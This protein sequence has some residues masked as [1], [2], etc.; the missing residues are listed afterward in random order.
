M[1]RGFV[2]RL[3][4]RHKLVLITTVTST[5][6]L[7]VTVLAF[8]FYDRA[9]IT[10]EMTH[11]MQVQAAI[12][13]GN[14]AAVVA[15]GNSQEGEVIL[16]ALHANPQVDQAAL[17][18]KDRTLLSSYMQQPGG[19][20]FVPVK[21]PPP[22]AEARFGYVVIC[23]P[24]FL[25]G[26]EVGTIWLS[27]SMERLNARQQAY[28]GIAGVLILISIVVVLVATRWLQGIILSPILKLVQTMSRISRQKD[29]AVRVP[30][31]GKDELG[32]LV[33]SFNLMLGEIEQRDRQLEL[34]VDQRT[35]ELSLEVQERKKAEEGLAQALQQAQ[36]MAEA[37]RA[38]NEAKSQFL[39]NMSHEIRTPMNG[40]LGMTSLLL[41]TAL[42]EDQSE[43]AKTIQRSADSLMEIIND[44]LDFSKAEAGKLV[45]E[46]GEFSLRTLFEEVGELFGPLA[47]AKNLSLL[48]FADPDIPHVLVGDGAK[49][50]QVL[51]NLIGNALKFTQEGEIRVNADLMSLQNGVAELQLSVTDTGPGI[52]EEKREAIFDS[53]TQVDGSS[54]RK[55][56][57]T[58]LGLTICRQIINA[59]HGRIWAESVLGVGSVFTAA[60]ALQVGSVQ[61]SENDLAGLSALVFEPHGGLRE[62]LEEQFAAWECNCDSVDISTSAIERLERGDRY[63]FV[64]VD[65]R[66]FSGVPGLPLSNLL[67]ELAKRDMPTV[68]V[69]SVSM[70]EPKERV[71]VLR[72]RATITVPLKM[73]LLYSSLC[74][75]LRQKNLSES[76]GTDARESVLIVSEDEPVA[77]ASAA[78]LEDRGFIVERAHNGIEALA[79]LEEHPFSFV[80]IDSES[81]LLDGFETTRCIRQIGTGHG[82]QPTIIGC[83]S[84][85]TPENRELC[86]QVGMDDWL[87]KPVDP[88]QICE[89]VSRWARHRQAGLPTAA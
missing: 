14:S 85:D 7:V 86:L 38:A 27:A 34:R 26:K 2:S 23:Q 37:A 21:A 71:G 50:K 25:D 68:L 57:G 77:S 35:R 63:D 15:E 47:E 59:M 65:I 18:R 24:I 43:L 78:S 80:V 81:K 33:H 36:D 76:L 74:Q 16:Q 48:C 4:L 88:G 60:V 11:Q 3:A 12:I 32:H 8:G 75:L 29:Y 83:L 17:Y 9:S 20:W 22:K 39:A 64:I 89:V 6:A 1:R 41:E 19:A 58:G 84:E 82:R 5:I 66:S 69:T 49:L 30:E 70:R 51:S 54:T 31:V 56:G 42:T 72:F 40:V 13:A 28:F 52:P 55:F 46:D 44:I 45:L 53:F 87:V 10:S 67:E 73:S 79:K 62:S 61:I